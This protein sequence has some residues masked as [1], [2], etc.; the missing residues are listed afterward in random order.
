M[1]VRP[2]DGGIFSNERPSSQETPVCVEKL[3]NPSRTS[4][5][6]QVRRAFWEAAKSSSSSLGLCLRMGSNGRQGTGIKGGEAL[7]CVGRVSRSCYLWSVSS[8]Q[9]TVGPIPAS[10]RSVSS[11]RFTSTALCSPSLRQSVICSW[12]SNSQN[13]LNLLV[14]FTS[15][16]IRLGDPLRP[17]PLV[18][19]APD[20][21]CDPSHALSAE[22]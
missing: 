6:G 5:K 18:L 3:R 17:L 22:R 13:P 19:P 11:P 2:S 4:A 16:L 7:Q 12:E 9:N 8:R 21:R 15:F 10:Q 1:P 20:L 14:L